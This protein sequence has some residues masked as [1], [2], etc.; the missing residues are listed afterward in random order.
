MNGNLFL[1]HPVANNRDL[2]IFK[3]GNGESG[4]GERG[5]GNGEWRTGNGEW[6]TGNGELGTGIGERGM[7]NGEW[8]TGESGNLN[9]IKSTEADFHSSRN[10]QNCM[11]AGMEY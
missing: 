1:G 6:G 5:M 8:G 4:N 7:G 11:P 2:A 10:K 9:L 3:T